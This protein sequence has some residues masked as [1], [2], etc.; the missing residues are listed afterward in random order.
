MKNQINI[1][2][3]YALSLSLILSLPPL[4]SPGS[5]IEVKVGSN[6]MKCKTEEQWRNI[7]VTQCSLRGGDDTPPSLYSAQVS[8]Y[9]TDLITV[10]P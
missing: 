5:C 7:G 6:V 2:K 8:I 10:L 9:N 4:V 1:H 3:A